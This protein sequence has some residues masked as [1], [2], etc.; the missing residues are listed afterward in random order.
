MIDFDTLDVTAPSLPAY[1]RQQMRSEALSAAVERD[2]P[3]TVVWHDSMRRIGSCG[4][5]GLLQYPAH[6]S[7]CQGH[8]VTIPSDYSH[9]KMSEAIAR[10][11]ANIQRSKEQHRAYL[12]ESS[13]R[14]AESNRRRAKARKAAIAEGDS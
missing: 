5:C 6:W 14:I 4:R 10:I 1:V 8:A 11:D 7:E 2:P 12:R 3:P 9:A 13:Q